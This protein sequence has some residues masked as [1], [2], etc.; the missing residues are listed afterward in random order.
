M[1]QR[2]AI[3]KKRRGARY[4]APQIGALVGVVWLLVWLSSNLSD[5]LARRGI[6]TGFDFLDRAARF[7]IAESL[8]SYEPT[9]SFGWAIVVGLGNTLFITFLVVVLST[10]LGLFVALAR[11]SRHPFAK[12]LSAALVDTMRNTPLVVQLLFVYAL[13]T[14]GLPNSEAAL[15]PLPGVFLTDRGL[16]LPTLGFSGGWSPSLLLGMII[17]VW[18]LPGILALVGR[19][20]PRTIGRARVRLLVAAVLVLVFIASGMRVDAEYPELGR[21]NF[22]GGMVLTPEFVA[23]FVGLLV[24]STVFA[25]EIIRGGI[26]AV[27]RGQW[28]AAGA[29]ALSERQAL[30]LVVLPQALRII[31]P[32]MTSQYVNVLKNS[33]LALV[34]GYPEA[35]FV[36]ATTINQTGQ[37]I[38][39]I[40]LLMIIFLTLSLV[41]SWLMNK[42]NQAF[43][44]VTR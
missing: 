9:D 36:I 5:N 7:P 31:I 28:E 21:F 14:I 43:A 16:Y 22:M 44:I 29:G 30:R 2:P 20:L 34:V 23:V 12:G 3:P 42:L 27:P 4:W 6:M 25:A 40:L 13:V 17:L 11:R 15:S 39:C 19:P 37:A 24:Y 8:L 10:I 1:A 35:N 32:P 38:E 41:A 26:D 18:L 33:T